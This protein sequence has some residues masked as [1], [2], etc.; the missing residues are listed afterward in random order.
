MSV[1]ETSMSLLFYSTISIALGGLVTAPFSSWQ[2]VIIREWL[3]FV[4]TG[5]LTGGAHFLMVEA[6]RLCEAALVAP[7][8][9]TSILWAILFGYFIFREVPEL[10]TLVGASVVISSG[11]YILHRERKLRRENL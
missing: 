10:N 11:I 3:F 7:F 8:K 1:S 5:L 6:F 2:P 4:L 9:Y